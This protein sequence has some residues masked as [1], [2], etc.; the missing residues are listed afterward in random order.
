MITAADS[1]A[2][3]ATLASIME[4]L[5]QNF[6]ERSAEIVALQR[7]FASAGQAVD[8]KERT[9]LA[10]ISGVL[11]LNAYPWATVESVVDQ[12]SG[13]AVD[14]PQERSTPLRLSVPVGTYRVSFRHPQA[15]TPVALVAGVEAQKEQSA[16]ATFPTLTARDYLRRVGYGQ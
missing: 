9:R 8:E 5:R 3:L 1:P 4:S 10:A 11:L 14:L 12:A 16:N 15:G 7:S 2:K 13:R 6:G